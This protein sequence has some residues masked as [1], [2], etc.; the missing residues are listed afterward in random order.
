MAMTASKLAFIEPL[1][2]ARNNVFACIISF[3]PLN[4]QWDKY[5]FPNFTYEEKKGLE[6]LSFVQIHAAGKKLS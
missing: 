2:N 4:I 5:Y 6:K 3:K 1:I